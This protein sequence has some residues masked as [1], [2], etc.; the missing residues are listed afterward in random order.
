MSD[1]IKT[2]EYDRVGDALEDSRKVIS[3][4]A[5]CVGSMNMT[6]ISTKAYSRTVYSKWGIG[7]D[8]AK[9]TFGDTT[10]MAINKSKLTFNWR[11]STVG[12]GS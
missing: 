4:D 10:Q 9:S 11:Y 1:V 6:P 5:W 12:H 8:T 3:H 2:L 7:L